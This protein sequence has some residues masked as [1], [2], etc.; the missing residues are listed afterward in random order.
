MNFKFNKISKIILGVVA[1]MLASCSSEL[2][3][4]DNN[5]ISVTGTAKRPLSVSVEGATRSIVSVKT[6]NKWVAGDRF[7]A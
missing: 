4:D 2:N 7:S 5:A 1:V 6:G 3:G